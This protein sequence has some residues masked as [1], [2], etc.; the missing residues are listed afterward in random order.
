MIY[1]YVTT[2][3]Y[4]GIKLATHAIG[5]DEYREWFAEWGEPRECDFIGPRGSEE[6]AIADAQELIDDELLPPLPFTAESILKAPPEPPVLQGLRSMTRAEAL[7]EL[8]TRPELGNLYCF[9]TGDED[10][11]GRFKSIADEVVE[12]G[13]TAEELKRWLASPRDEMPWRARR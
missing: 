6:E 5:N 9:L 11:A 8:S 4:R 13:V 7:E 1:P 12:Y 2:T 3:T 10:Y